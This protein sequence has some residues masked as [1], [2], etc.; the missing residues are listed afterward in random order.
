MHPGNGLQSVVVHSK[1]LTS[2]FALTRGKLNLNA[3]AVVDAREMSE[4][5]F[6]RGKLNPNADADVDARDAVVDAREKMS[7]LPIGTSMHQCSHHR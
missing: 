6:T 5:A 1:I 2:E 3:D 4:F 7:E